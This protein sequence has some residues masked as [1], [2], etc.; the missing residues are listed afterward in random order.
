MISNPFNYILSSTS[1]SD[2]VV[3]ICN[4]MCSFFFFFYIR[5]GVSYL[6]FNMTRACIS[7]TINISQYSHNTLTLSNTSLCSQTSL[8]CLI[9]PSVNC[10]TRSRLCTRVVHKHVTFQQ[11]FQR[12]VAVLVTC[13]LI[14]CTW[15][16]DESV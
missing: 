6:H 4:Y 3:F 1:S 9:F 12:L 8:M 7:I 5:G 10:Q 15:R 2:T 14:A 16:R 13:P 11:Y